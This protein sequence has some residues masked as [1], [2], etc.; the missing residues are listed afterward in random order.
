M[1]LVQVNLIGS[2]VYRRQPESKL[3]FRENELSNLH[4]TQSDLLKEAL[5]YVKVNGILCYM[6]CSIRRSENMDQIRKFL[7]ESN[8]KVELINRET[9]IPQINGTDGFFYC[10]LK[11]IDI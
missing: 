7:V 5:T 9:I 8:G 10:E 3:E 2:G 1:C 11:K 4:Q 6:T